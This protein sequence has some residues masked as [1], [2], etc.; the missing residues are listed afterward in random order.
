[1]SVEKARSGWVCRIRLR[2]G[3]QVRVQIPVA[4]KREATVAERELRS[5][6]RAGVGKEGLLAAAVAFGR[7]R[8]HGLEACRQARAVAAPKATQRPPGGK[9]PYTF[10]DVGDMWADGSLARTY[11]DTVRAKRS[12]KQDRSRLRILYRTIG[13][14]P[15]AALTL[16]DADR[17]IASLP[18]GLSPS[19]IRQY[20][21]LIRTVL[22]L[23]AYP[24]RLR[25][26]MAYPDRWFTT[27]G[28][29]KAK[30]YLWPQEE[31]L[32]LRCREIPVERRLLYGVLAREGMRLS[33]AL[34]LQW[35]DVDLDVGLVRLDTNKT[36]DPRAW[37]LSRAVVYALRAWRRQTAPRSSE[38]TIFPET[39][40][41]RSWARVFRNDLRTAGVTR[42]ELFERSDERLPIRLH[43]LRG[44][45]VTIALANGRSE[46]W[47]TDR[48]GHKSSAMIY[49]YKSSARTAAE[50]ELGDWGPLTPAL[51]RNGTPGS[52]SASAARPEELG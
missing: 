22:S 4:T 44:S 52:E 3:P 14:I 5:A 47:V 49:R 36:D 25:D 10:A 45:F 37:A 41:G 1:M 26:P 39:P 48:T 12:A 13:H 16:E 34:S 15:V 24:L 21:Q 31:Q 35:G 7:S 38:A 27:I 18:P 2:S 11:P 23:A 30:S 40:S 8:E 42:P 33:E 6:A 43:D 17:A 50:L 28:R 19:S 46:T 51:R 20:K 9:G 32:L 29:Q